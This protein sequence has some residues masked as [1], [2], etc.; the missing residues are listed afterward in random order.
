[1]EMYNDLGAPGL[2]EEAAAAEGGRSDFH[3]LA[4]RRQETATAYSCLE[5]VML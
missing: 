3:V 4:S 2:K 5:V 1:M